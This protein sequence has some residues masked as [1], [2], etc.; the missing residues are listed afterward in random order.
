MSALR[1]LADVI[2]VVSYFRTAPIADETNNLEKIKTQGPLC[3]PGMRTFDTLLPLTN[4]RY[5]ETNLSK[6][7]SPN[8]PDRKSVV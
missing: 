7:I 4:D 2:A 3:Q 6:L 5:P 1:R 8:N